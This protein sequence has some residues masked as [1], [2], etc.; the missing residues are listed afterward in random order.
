MRDYFVTAIGNRAVDIA[1]SVSNE[2]LCRTHLEI[3]EFQVGDIRRG[4]LHSLWRLSQQKRGGKRACNHHEHSDPDN[5]TAGVAFLSDRS[6]LSQAAHEGHCRP[7][8]F[9]CRFYLDKLEER[10]HGPYAEERR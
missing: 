6:W 9:D 8:F 10:Q 3:R 5:H 1:H 4:S 7:L 2:I